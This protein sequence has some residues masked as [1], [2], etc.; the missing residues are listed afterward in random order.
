MGL[1][2]RHDPQF[3]IAELPPPPSADHLHHERVG[4]VRRPVDDED[5][6]HGGDGD[7]H[8]D[9][10]GRERPADFQ[11]DVTVNLSR[12]PAAGP[13]PKPED[14]VDEDALHHDEDADRPPENLVE[15]PVKTCGGIRTGMQGGLRI[16]AATAL[17][18]QHP[19]TKQDRRECG[20]AGRPWR[21]GRSKRH[22]EGAAAG[23]SPRAAGQG[24]IYERSGNVSTGMG[25]A[26]RSARGTVVGDG[27]QVKERPAAPSWR[28][29]GGAPGPQTGAA[30]RLGQ[31]ACGTSPTGVTRPPYRSLT[32]SPYPLKG[33]VGIRSP[34]PTIS[35]WACDHRGC[36]TPGST[37]E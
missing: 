16:F 11:Q 10:R 12:A 30:S 31:R 21:D 9:E 18:D 32:H 15:Q 17:Q 19:E 28:R 5:R 36:G 27:G 26:S 4:I 37:L 20:E 29:G 13:L 23:L 14:R 8:Q 22:D 24:R 33:N 25:P 3:R 34:V 1:V 35:S 7:G 2:G 6:L